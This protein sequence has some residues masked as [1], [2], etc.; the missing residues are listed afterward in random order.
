[1]R[2][3]LAD[4][5]YAVRL[6]IRTPAASAVAVSVIAVAM[7][8]VATFLSLYNDLVFDS[9]SEF[10]HGGELITV[11]MS[12]GVVFDE[13]SL[14]L[15]NEINAQVSS[16]NSIAGSMLRDQAVVLHDDQTQLK[17]E[18]VTDRYF[19]DI[20]PR[21]LLGRP[22]GA[23]DHSPD[24]E[25][26]AVL[27][28]DYW[29]R[30]FG[31]SQDVIGSV[32]RMST[33]TPDPPPEQDAFS[34]ARI[35]R[36]IGVMA[37]GVDGT[38]F[39]G[40]QVWMPFEQMPMIVYG[41]SLRDGYEQLP[42]L[43]G[44]GRVA[45]GNTAAGVAAEL[46]ARFA[47]QD[48]DL[49]VFP[50][51][52]RFD[53]LPALNTQLQAWRE[54]KRQVQLFLGGSVLLLLVAA[55]NVSLFLLARAPARRRELSIRMALGSSVARL[56]RQL[57]T[58]AGLI[59]VVSTVIG[60]VAS[61]WFTSVI[62]GLPFLQSS[63][64]LSA[65][66]LEWR[67][68]GMTALFM[69]LLA[70]IVSLVPIAGLGRL[71]IASTARSFTARAG[72]AQRMAGTVQIAIAGALGAAALAFSWHVV[73][74]VTS[75]PGFTV[76][77]LYVIAPQLEPVD[78]R[79][80]VEPL[81]L[82]RERRREVIEGLPGVERVAFGTAVPGRDR[83]LGERRILIP[84]RPALIESSL[85]L[86]IDSADHMFTEVLDLQIIHGRAP[87][88]VN[89][90]DVLVNETF[91]RAIGNPADAVG[92][93]I[94]DKYTIVGVVENVSYSHP[95]DAVPPRILS[96]AFVSARNEQILVKW[97]FSTT[98]LRQGVQS[99]IDA[100]ELDFVIDSVDRLEDLASVPM[101]EDRA[102]MALIVVAAAFVVALAGL[103]FYGTQH[104]LIG[105]GRREYAIR[106]ALGAEPGMIQRTVQMRAFALGLPGL[107]LGTLLAFVLV[108]WL[109]SDFVGPA[110]SPG[111]VA[112]LVAIGI[113]VL[114]F[115][116]SLGP[117][118]HARNIQTAAALRDE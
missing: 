1:M 75:D 16:L 64:W 40:V 34:E 93:A 42:T 53:T 39:P 103:G 15:I 22:F 110:V 49:G 33:I 86:N 70:L 26:V 107:V 37:P 104:Y 66:P 32:M 24:A 87:N 9:Q 48:F 3:M 12:D 38:F 116:A 98:R 58:E 27:S 59:V 11:A 62:R 90:S 35:Y 88:P 81:I 18:F 89:R 55:S 106:T 94:N 77:D 43:F 95:D 2:G 23:Q 7:A 13:I 4:L 73:A 57:A 100:G 28:Y 82:D 41:H 109:R 85:V 80:D 68:L 111:A 91:A 45:E 102:R 105:A 10:E 46:R 6:Y 72:P 97:P 114:V 56:A 8:A 47:E 52:E 31:G 25:P 92:E 69:L 84:G 5:R 29:Q 50:S 51:Q 76:E 44:V 96:Q 83:A 113:A 78:S 118:R 19:T 60:F 61:F 74:L 65:S 30:N 101:S 71:G 108:V 17:I 67:V 63:L 21:L 112:V 99:L 79:A 20:R 117:A 14:R 36:V 115:T 54:L